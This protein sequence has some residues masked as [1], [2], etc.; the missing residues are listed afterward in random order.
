[1]RR[2]DGG[3]GG[4]QLVRWAVAMSAV[5]SV[6]VEVTDIRGARETPGLRPQHV[7]AVT[8]AAKFAD[9]TV[10]GVEV[11]SEAITFDPE[12]VTGGSHSIDVG[13]AGSVALVF[14]TILPLAVRAREPIVLAAT[15]GTDVKWAPPIDYHRFVK[16]PALHRWGLESRLEVHRRGF[17]PKGGGKATL[18]AEPARGGQITVTD[19]GGLESIAVHSIATADL[20]DADVAERQAAAAQ[21][22]LEDVVPVAVDTSSTHTEADST[23]SVVLLVA[24]YEHSRAGFSALGEPGKPAEQVAA[25][26]IADFEAFDRA[27]GAVDPHLADQLLPFLAERGGEITTTETTTHIE[28]AIDLLAEFDYEIEL[29]VTDEEVRLSAPARSPG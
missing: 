13:T 9:A 28:T 5:R 20:E 17:Y 1:M 11:G 27:A 14:D 26:A 4:G 23:G 22:R 10:S 18:A 12:S 25:A 29:A 16:L 21:E 7:A 24:E 6:P 8:A 3:A 2:I 15:G 19:R